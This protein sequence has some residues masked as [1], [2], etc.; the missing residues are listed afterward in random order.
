MPIEL[1]PPP[2]ARSFA[3]TT[4]PRSADMTA[5]IAVG[6]T[7][8]PRRARH[9]RLRR[10]TVWTL[11]VNAQVKLNFACGIHVAL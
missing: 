2:L 5:E 11:R 1:T 7:A 9:T 3:Q 4:T 10:T 6:V 8:R